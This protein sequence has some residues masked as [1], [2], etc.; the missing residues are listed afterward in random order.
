M[1]TIHDLDPPYTHGMLGIAQ[2]MC[3]RHAALCFYIPHTQWEKGRCVGF[4]NFLAHGVNTQS[5]MS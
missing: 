5:D 2:D 3:A 4:G 1:T